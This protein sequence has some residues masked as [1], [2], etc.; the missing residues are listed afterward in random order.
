MYPPTRPVR[1]L[2][3][4]LLFL[5][6]SLDTRCRN[7]HVTHCKVRPK[8]RPYTGRLPSTLPSRDCHDIHH[9]IYCRKREHGHGVGHRWP[10]DA[11]P[12]RG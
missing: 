1:S 7:T 10:L 6:P 9:G 3:A 5:F 2:T 12:M 11:P 4:S 8:T